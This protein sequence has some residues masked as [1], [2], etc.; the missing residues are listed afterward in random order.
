ML[1]TYVDI[2]HRGLGVAPGVRAPGVQELR[3]DP[4]HREVYAVFSL[5]AGRDFRLTSSM[6]HYKQPANRSIATNF[7]GKGRRTIGIQR[8]AP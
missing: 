8:R 6:D 3:A 7:H 1:A 2:Q 5:D 4:P